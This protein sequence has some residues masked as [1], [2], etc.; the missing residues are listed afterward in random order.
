MRKEVSALIPVNNFH[1]RKGFGVQNQQ[2]TPLNIPHNATVATMVPKTLETILELL[3]LLLLIR[4]LATHG[5]SLIGGLFSAHH[6]VLAI[7]G[8][9]LASAEPAA[10]RGAWLSLR[11]HWL[12]ATTQS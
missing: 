2:A 10:L 11:G 12:A 6:A 1:E 8:A 9:M 3:L 7:P 4:G 5:Q